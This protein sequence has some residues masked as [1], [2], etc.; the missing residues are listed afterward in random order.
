MVVRTLEETARLVHRYRWLEARTFELLGGWVAVERAPEVQRLFGVQAHHHAWHAE[1]WEQRLPSAR[2][3]SPPVPDSVPPG[4]EAF[5]DAL[6][7]PTGPE[8]T[9]ERL[10]GVYR[11]LVPHK[12]T[13]YRRH[14]AE[15]SPVADGPV[16]R[17]LRLALRD[18]L[19]DWQE[20]EAMLQER[21][22]TPELARRAAE[23]QGVLEALLVAAGGI[24]GGFRAAPASIG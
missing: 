7:Q 3:A 23:R 9:V 21:L 18:E 8:A 16:A 10:V 22:T 2:G 1:L 5:V 17:A 20:G 24:S 12:L 15:V 11:V 4:L 19:D 6:A 14:L 13:T